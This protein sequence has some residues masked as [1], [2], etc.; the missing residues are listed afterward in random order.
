MLSTQGVE[1]GK[2]LSSP[3]LHRLR[4][5]ATPTEV[6]GTGYRSDSSRVLEIGDVL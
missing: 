5:D 1:K 4:G 6:Q 2:H 3:E